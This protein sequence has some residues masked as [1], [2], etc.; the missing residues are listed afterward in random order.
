M[1]NWKPEGSICLAGCPQSKRPTE[2]KKAFFETLKCWKREW[3]SVTAKSKDCHPQGFPDYLMRFLFSFQQGYRFQIQIFPFHS[4][5]CLAVSGKDL[6]CSQGNFYLKSLLI[7]MENLGRL[8]LILMSHICFTHMLSLSLSLSLY[9]S[10]KPLMWIKFWWCLMLMMM[11]VFIRWILLMNEG[12]Y[13]F[14]WMNLNWWY[15]KVSG[16]C[17]CHQWLVTCVRGW[18]VIK[19]PINNV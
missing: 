1:C 4:V 12:M 3:N 15:S 9:I 14:P 10:L 5:A 18:Y 19:I 11:R 8:L 2:R 6:P 7:S 13:Q 16:C 17:W